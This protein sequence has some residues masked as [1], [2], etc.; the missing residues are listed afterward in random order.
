MRYL[1][2][3]EAKNAEKFMKIAAGEATRSTCKKSQRGA[4]IVKDNKIIGKGYNKVTLQPLCEPCIREKIE[5]NSRVELCSAIHA[6][7][8]AILDAIKNNFSLANS[9]MY[10]IKLKNGEMRQSGKPSCTVCSRIIQESGIKEFVLL[11]TSGYVAYTSEELNELSF[12]YFL[13]KEEL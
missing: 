3:S 12:R 4:I 8:L 11:H 1:T 7:Q 5:D 2:N 6:E 9:T 10:Q 13:N